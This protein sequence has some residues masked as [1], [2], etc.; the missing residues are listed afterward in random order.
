MY[1][2]QLVQTVPGDPQPLHQAVLAVA[3][4]QSETHIRHIVPGQEQP[5][6]A[7]QS[8]PG[9]HQHP[10]GV[11]VHQLSEEEAGAQGGPGGVA[12]REG[13]ALHEEG[14]EEVRAVLGRPATSHKGLHQSDQQQVQ[15]QSWDRGWGRAKTYQ[16][17]GFGQEMLS[18]LVSFVS[19]TNI[20]IKQKL[21]NL[22][23]S[24]LYPE[25]TGSKVKSGFY[26]FLSKLN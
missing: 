4:G 12:R 13:V 16:S 6:E 23:V 17:C 25:R 9:H 3:H 5:R 8:G 14:G 7:D 11:R 10:H 15:Q 22:E 19:I 24:D 1:Q 20:S 26:Y 21:F 18:S 2:L